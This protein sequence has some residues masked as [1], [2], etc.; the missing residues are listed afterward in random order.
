MD[1]NFQDSVIGR[2]TYGVGLV[3]LGFGASVPALAVERVI[4][5]G[6][7]VYSCGAAR[8]GDV[9]TIPAGTRGPLIIRDC[10]G[11]ASNPII[12]RNDPDGGGPAIIRRSGGSGGFILSCINCIGVTIDGGSKWRGAPSGQ[13]Y[14]IQV[15]VSSGSPSAFVRLSGFTRSLTVRNIEVDGAGAK[16]GSGIR[17]NDLDVKRSR[18][19]GMWREDILIEDNFV[20]DIANEGMYIGPN[21]SDGALPLRN[22]EI[23]R[24][25][26]EDIGWEAINTKS[27]W[28]GNNSIHHNKVVR[29]GKNSSNTSKAAQ[30]T[31]I[32]AVSSTVKIY[33]NWVETTGMHG[34][35]VYSSSGPRASEG[36]GPFN[37][38]IWNNVIVDAGAL[39]K[40]FMLDSS[41]INVGASAGLEKPNPRIYSN[42]IVNPR[43]AAI[44][45]LSNVGPGYVR[46]NISA[47]AGQNPVIKAPKQVQLVNNQVGSVASL[48]FV[49]PS[50]KDFRLKT[51]SPARNQGTSSFPDDDFDNVQR[52][53]EGSADQGAFEGNN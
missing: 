11:T 15:T 52:P 22:I 32:N 33:N 13:T 12:V 40:S 48:Q 5:A 6:T 46:D 28:E 18:Y 30:Y 9:L 2:L 20:H 3:I 51:G 10:D 49:D 34:I 17:L 50:R 25:R 45:V 7:D 4:S 53:K 8:P 16:S 44:S 47:G 41:G 36:R 35:Q 31:G 37:A 1:L 39:W 43:R 29:A 21:Y 42:T 26:L 24:N 14:G 23:R 38:E 19:P 27:M